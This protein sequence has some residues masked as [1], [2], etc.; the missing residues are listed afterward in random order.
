[1]LELS[2]LKCCDFKHEG[3]WE[4]CLSGTQ[5][6]NSIQNISHSN[7]L[8]IGGPN[9]HKS[10]LV[11][12]ENACEIKVLSNPCL[13]WH[14]SHISFSL[15]VPSHLERKEM[16]YGK[17]S[18]ES[19]GF[20]EFMLLIKL[21]FLADQGQMTEFNRIFPLMSRF[22]TSKTSQ[23]DRAGGCQGPLLSLRWEADGERTFKDLLQSC[24]NTCSG[25][26]WPG[27]TGCEGS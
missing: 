11:L 10:G 7:W 14:S 24:V 17:P 23:R 1:M 16:V 25:W 6:D 15:V 3:I 4:V 20:T 9:L 12:L 13:M 18:W 8:L 2:F 22:F 26:P 21:R 27:Q 5:L 19:E